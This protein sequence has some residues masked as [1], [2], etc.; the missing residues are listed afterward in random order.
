MDIALAINLARRKDRWRNVV[1]I[2][3]ELGVDLHRVRGVD[4]KMLESQNGHI[5]VHKSLVRLSWTDS[6][7]KQ[8]CVGH[9]KLS[10]KLRAMVRKGSVSPWSCY[11]CNRSHSIALH[12]ARKLLDDGTAKNVLILEDD[13]EL[14]AGGLSRIRKAIARL[15]RGHPGWRMLVLG[16]VAQ[17]L[18]AKQT[19][20][21]E[22]FDGVH[23]AERVYQSHAYVVR[24]VEAVDYI[25]E[26][27]DDKHLV[28][29]GA[30]ARAQAH[31][32]WETFFLKPAAVTQ[33]HFGSDILA[34]QSG[35]QKGW[36][37]A[38]ATDSQPR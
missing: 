8:R 2:A 17:D 14:L 20:H 11:G 36:L 24:D 28:A 23:Y 3:K 13:A 34:D 10:K 15:G 26:G 32:C 6:K 25:L 9:I 37:S 30:T 16:G 29:D 27:L 22:A 35:G 18:W 31:F 33:G 4:G 1:S 5:R 7:S 12:K 19:C 21:E 38:W